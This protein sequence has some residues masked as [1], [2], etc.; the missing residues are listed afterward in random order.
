MR[1]TMVR[2]LKQLLS[3]E[4]GQALSIVLGLLAIGGLTIAVSL[5]YAT[6]NLKG[7][8]IVEEKTDGI[9]AAGAGVEHALWSLRNGLWSLEKGDITDNATPE[10]INQMAVNIQTE[11]KGTFTLWFGTLT[12]ELGVQYWKVSVNGT[13][14]S[15]GGNRYKY[16]ITANQTAESGQ[17]IFLESV[18][19]RIPVGFHYEAGSITRSDI[20]RVHDPDITQDDYGAELLN[21]PWK[22]WNNATWNKDPKMELRPEL[23]GVGDVYTQTFY[24]TRVTG[25]GSTEGEYCW[26]EGQP[27][28]IGIVGEVTGTWYRITA[29]ATRPE[30]GRTTAEIVANVMIRNDGVTFI[31]SWQITK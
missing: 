28:S 6:T 22:D 8:Q 15:V 21:W 1:N 20:E 30:D 2:L 11:H 26:V 18:G 19:V 23:K 14:S 9:Y 4:K 5:N 17:N 10:N 29:T 12:A 3:S 16:E 13:M 7:S 27:T 24:V 31:N 25:K